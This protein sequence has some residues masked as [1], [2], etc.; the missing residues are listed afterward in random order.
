VKAPSARTVA[1]RV[2]KLREAGKQY[3]EDI[4]A[5]ELS[6]NAL[7]QEDRALAQELA[8]GTARWQATLDWL[9]QRKTPPGR[10]QRDAL[11][12][13]LRL[14]LYQLFWLERI[15]DHAAVHE[16]VEM[17]KQL[18]FGHQAG[19]INAVLRTYLRERT[20]TEALLEELKE[21]QP[22]LGYSHPEWLWKRWERRWGRLAALELLRLNNQPPVTFARV[23]SLRTT[24]ESLLEQWQIEKVIAQPRDFAWTPPRL[25]FELKSHPRFRE[26]ASFNQGFY[27]IQDPSTLLAVCLLAP[28]RNET[29]LD[30]CAAPGGKTTYM[31]QLMGNQ[32]RVIAQD[33]WTDRLK[34]LHEN[35][36]RL[37]V[38][39]VIIQPNTP[40][41]SNPPAPQIFDRV[42]VDAPCSNT[43]VLRRRVDLRWRIRSE[44]IERLQTTQQSILSG[45]AR[46]IRVG[47]RLVYS[48]CSLEEEE[49]QKVIANFLTEHANFTLEVE[50]ELLPFREFVDGGYAAQ[51]IRQA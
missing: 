33:L 22:A 29:I 11:L 25:V 17:A 8:Y 23:N 5:S 27:Y 7:E 36:A 9:I 16:T 45:A 21:T 2:L 34:L 51:L 4:L 46:Q 3:T 6:S 14:G 43:G 31:A 35:C 42:L 49:N 26:L 10:T 28:E 32:G 38:T 41:S 48:T 24:P 1:F 47:G 37:G 40:E 15:P 13:L 19:F 12:V 44:E 18:G 30:V 20:Q 50:K 39:C